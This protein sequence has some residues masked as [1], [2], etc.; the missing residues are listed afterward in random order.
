[1]RYRETQH[2]LHKLVK[3]CIER[4]VHLNLNAQ[5]R[6]ASRVKRLWFVVQVSNLKWNLT[7]PG[8]MELPTITTA[9]MIEVGILTTHV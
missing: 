3:F 4:R 5:G 9:A 2:Y 7:F 1:M 8:W 6:R